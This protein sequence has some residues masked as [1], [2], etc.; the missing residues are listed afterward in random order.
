[1]VPVSSPAP[2]YLV[3]SGIFRTRTITNSEEAKQEHGPRDTLTTVLHQ[4]QR[5]KDQLLGVECFQWELSRPLY[6]SSL[7]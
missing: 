1:M 2:D 4:P 3:F 6:C 7:R 5:L